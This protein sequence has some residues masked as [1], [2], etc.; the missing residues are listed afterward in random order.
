[1]TFSEMTFSEMTFSEAFMNA[2]V[3]NHKEAKNAYAAIS[4]EKVTR[5]SDFQLFLIDHN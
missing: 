3:R 4:P 1:M 2:V 5:S